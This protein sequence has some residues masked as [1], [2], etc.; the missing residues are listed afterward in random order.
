MRAV[1]PGMYLNKYNKSV[2]CFK[3][4][5]PTKYWVEKTVCFSLCHAIA[6]AVTVSPHTSHFF[7]M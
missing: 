2:M 4:I 3:V 6:P 1:C 7:L 5:L